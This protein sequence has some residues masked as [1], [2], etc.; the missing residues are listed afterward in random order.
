M[1]K[2]FK[3]SDSLFYLDFWPFDA[4]YLIVSSPSAAIEACQQHDLPKPE[5]LKPFFHPFAGGENL[6]TMNGPEWKRS[7]AMF[8]PGFSTNYILSQISH[9]VEESSVW[10]EILREHATKEK[11]FSMD[12]GLLWFT[13]D[14]IGAVTLNSRLN[15]Q[16]RY[17]PLASAMRSQIRWHSTN[18][19]MNPFVRFN[20]IRPIVQW[21]NGYRMD[22]YISKELD[23]RFVE[24]Q[25]GNKDSS[26]RSVI[27]LVLN[28]YMSDRPNAQ[29]SKEMDKS[30]KDWAIIQIRLFI[31]AG[32]DSTASTIGYS[33]YLLSKHPEA[34]D[35]V[36]AEHDEV[37]GTDISNVA[38]ILLE[39]PYLINQLPYT[40]AIVKEA[41]RLFAPANGARA[42]L[43]GVFLHDKD[44]NQYDTEGVLVLIIHGRIHRNPDYWKD[45]DSFIPDRWLVGPEDPLYPVKGAWRPFEYGKRD[46]LGQTLVVVDVLTVLAMTLREFDFHSAY[47]EWDQLHPRKGIKTVHGERAY[48]VM[49]G[50]FHP[51]DGLPFRVTMRT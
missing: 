35:K 42:G 46:C 29:A 16:R 33:Y 28:N 6:F 24:R 26:S 7:R 1:A 40:L 36:R 19:E 38:N 8:N 41:M 31:F 17:N 5:E 34:L 43:P 20:P 30:F 12:D 39:Q 27:D 25:M 3:K 32:H 44:G 21:Y 37:F 50:A 22:S 11:M 49:A 14:I 45:P 4:Q 48:Q 18:Q 2:K 13:M 47:D 23:K 15:S 9:I 10:V 51:V